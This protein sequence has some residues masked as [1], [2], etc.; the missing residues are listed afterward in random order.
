MPLKSSATA[1]GKRPV[2]APRSAVSRSK[3]LANKKK[4]APAKKS[5]KVPAS[6]R[7]SHKARRHTAAFSTL[8]SRQLAVQ[9]A[10][11]QIWRHLQ[12]INGAVIKLAESGS[13]LAARTLFDFAG[14]YTL[15]P[16]EEETAPVSLPSAPAVTEAAPPALPEKPPP[17]NKI[18][19]FLQTLGLDS[20]SDDDPEPYTGA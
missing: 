1:S 10:K 19:A 13:Y 9:R 11:L 15:P 3:H 16:L 7:S 6:P 18:E 17:V 20:L 8:K 12:E 4:R 5:V 2:P 14:V